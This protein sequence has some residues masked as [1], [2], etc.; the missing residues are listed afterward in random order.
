MKE[1]YRRDKNKI[2]V[3]VLLLLLTSLLLSMSSYAWFSTNRLLTINTLNIQVAA[4]GGIEIS[5]DAIN[6]GAILITDDLGT[7]HDTTYR[8]SVNQL[9]FVFEPVSS[10]KTVT[11]GKLNMFYGTTN[12]ADILT[13]FELSATKDTEVE[14]FGDNSSGRFMAFDVFVRTSQPKILYLTKNSNIV[15]QGLD[16]NMGIENAFRVAFLV[17][18]NALSNSPTTYIQNMNNADEDSTYF[19]EPNYDTHTRNGVLNA[20][21]TYGIIT[22][23]T[24]GS[25]LN[26]D[27]IYSEIPD[28][29]N[30]LL[31][32]ATAQNYPELFR[33]VE[34]DFAT[35][36]GEQGNTEMFAI[37]SGVTKIRIYVWIE[38]Q[39]VDCENNASVGNVNF[40]LQL[41][42]DE[43]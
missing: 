22:T 32:N 21:N 4:S 39:D 13:S 15:Y 26:Y 42:T 3:L 11:D 5:A 40:N 28:E 14:G 36:T 31:N 35:R 43:S 27:G 9:P 41:S 29:L 38:G 18:G 33:P 24:N 30:V 37:S 19:W 1:D 12:N 2:F 6:W 7:V 23:Q 20:S 17:E 25:R 10:G 34:I 8:N 16:E